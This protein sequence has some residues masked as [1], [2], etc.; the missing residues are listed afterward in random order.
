MSRRVKRFLE[1]P[2]LR[3]QTGILKQTT[4]MM[5]TVY[6]KYSF[7][8]DM[9]GAVQGPYGNEIL[10]LFLRILRVEELW[11]GPELCSMR[12]R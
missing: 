6:W 4:L 8:H 5:T 12:C 3:V 10:A 1:G 11:E 7:L 2:K 9:L